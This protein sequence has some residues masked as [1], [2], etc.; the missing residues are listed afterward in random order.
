[1]ITVYTLDREDRLVDLSPNWDSFALANEGEAA[2]ASHVLGEPLMQNITGDPVRMFMTAVLMRVRVSGQP[3][4]APYRCDSETMKRLYHMT[5][6]PLEDGAVRITHVLDHEEPAARRVR[7]RPAAPGRPALQRCSICCRVKGAQGWADPFDAAADQD[8][9][10]IHTVCPDCKA[11][12]ARRPSPE[13]PK[14]IFGMTPR[15]SPV[16]ARGGGTTAR[17]APS[18]GAGA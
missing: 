13:V 2:C 18:D 8:L 16:D 10:V 11:R 9:R 3:E 4:T 1:M 15:L 12:G 6:E 5:L 17:A 14:E 7:I